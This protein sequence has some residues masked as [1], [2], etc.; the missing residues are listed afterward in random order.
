MKSRIEKVWIEHRQDQ[1]GDSSWLGTYSAEQPR[2][3]Y[4]V[5]RQQGALIDADS[6]RVIAD[7]LG[8]TWRRG[9]YQYISGFQHSGSVDSWSHVDDKGLAAAFLRLRYKANGNEQGIQSRNLF[10]YF[11]VQGWEHAHSRPAKIRKVDAVYCCLNALRLERLGQGDWHFIG[12]IATAEI[13]SAH[14]VTQTIRSGG[15]W[16]IESDSDKNYLWTEEQTQLREL[17]QELQALGFGPRV[18]N[19]AL[20][21]RETV[22]A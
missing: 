13:V 9:E 12:I 4:Y 6:G 8:A 10:A 1:S 21:N 15:L 5:D 20:R 22:T 14:G 18:I 11:G 3:G 2:S 19:R 17:K 7:S 16:G